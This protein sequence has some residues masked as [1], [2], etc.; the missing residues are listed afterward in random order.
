MDRLLPV[1]ILAAM[2]LGSAPVA[3]SPALHGDRRCC[4]GGSRCRSRWSVIMMY[5][6]L[7]KVRYDKLDTVTATTP[8]AASLLLNWVLALR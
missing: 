6:V 1:W 2:L 7:A 4:G 5:P 3:R 8:A